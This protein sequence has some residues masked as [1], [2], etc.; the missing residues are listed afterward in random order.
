M[1]LGKTAA[2]QVLIIFILIAVGFVLKKRGQ[3]SSG[4]VKDMTNILLG[5]VTPSVLIE[6]YQKEFDMSLAWGLL[7]CVLFTILVHIVA[8]LISTL[9][10]RKEETKRYRINIFCSVYSNC[11]FMA[12]PLMGALLGSDGVFFG[13][14]YLAVFTIFYW[15]HG[16]VLYTG[17]KK[18]LSLKKAFLNPGVI[19]T[20]ISL[21]LFITNTRLPGVLADS[22][23]FLAG[24]NTPLAMIVLGTYLADV[25][26]KKAIIRPALY[27]VSALRLFVIP[28]L[29]FGIA[30]LMR[31]TPMETQSVLIPAACPAA[32]VSTLFAARYG[33]DAEY[34]AELVALTTLFSI[35]TI[36]IVM[37]ISSFLA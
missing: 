30:F 24:L 9:A 27:G 15:T 28:I 37:G 34:S 36:P 7:R 25:D 23:G 12:I 29:S 32:A 20:V 18:D 13:S 26:F 31:L 22:I 1:E 10:F 3:V 11:G 2:L 6:A 14:S 19:G 35:L 4:G 33:L 8:I 17:D 21:L 5:V 16:V